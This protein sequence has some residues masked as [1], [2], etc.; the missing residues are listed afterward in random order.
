MTRH[1]TELLRAVGLPTQVPADPEVADVSED[2]REIKPG[3]LFVAI[4]GTTDSGLKYVDDAVGRGAVAIVSEQRTNA[5]VPVIV[6]R[7]ARAALADLAAAINDHPSRRIP[8]FGVTGTDGK[9]TTSFLLAS[10]LAQVGLRP[11]LI[12]TVETR[13]GG[14][15]VDRRDRLTTPSATYIQQS[16]ARMVAA[17]DGAAVIECSSHALA[18]DRLRN[19]VLRSAA[20][21]NI[22][23]DH[24]E[25]HGSREAYAQAKSRIA[26]LIEKRDGPELIVNRDDPTALATAHG[27]GRRLLTFGRSN[28]AD[29]R[30]ED[31]AG[32]LIETRFTVTFQGE[33][34]SVRLKSGGEYNVYNALAAI[35]LALTAPVDLAAAAAAISEADFP[36]GRLQPIDCGQP[37]SVFVDYAHT[38]QAF[39]SVIHFLHQAGRRTGGRLI[40]VFGAAGDRDRAKRPHLS[41]IAGRLC[42][43][44]VITNEDPYS[45]DSSNIGREIAAGAP[46]ETRGNQWTVEMD[47]RRAIELALDYA[48]SGDIVVITGKGHESTIAEGSRSIPW[49]DVATAR[50]LLTARIH[51]NVGAR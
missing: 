9:T 31:V 36:A 51:E 44:F 50:E 10:I 2:S 1:L 29:L 26:T 32:D 33:H 35:G 42:D 3:S 20:I 48:R 37:F 19:V 39:E 12:T 15:H 22:A 14:L 27:T 13:I 47:R 6:V 38:E 43:F 17:G 11:G 28:D 34:R 46:A 41:E 7:D 24:V 49:S 25:F 5:S 16:L 8:C 23:S 40:A 21:T 30:A 45:E 4:S 18:L